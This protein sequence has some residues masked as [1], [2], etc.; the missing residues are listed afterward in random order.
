MIAGLGFN[1]CCVWVMALY[2]CLYFGKVS[3]A[4]KCSRQ[5]VCPK[6]FCDIRCID[7]L[8]EPDNLASARFSKKLDNH[9]LSLSLVHLPVS[10]LK[11]RCRT[12]R[13]IRWKAYAAMRDKADSMP[14]TRRNRHSRASSAVSL[15]VVPCCLVLTHSNR[16]QVSAPSSLPNTLATASR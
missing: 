10:S 9:C 13:V 2:V 4:V 16:Y 12:D 11:A 3:I 6:R 7:K 5:Q 8:R 15:T 1:D 14:L